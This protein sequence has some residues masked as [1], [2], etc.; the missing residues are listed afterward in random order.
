MGRD[1]VKEELL[2]CNDEFRR[3]Y[4]EHRQYDQ[5]LTHLRAKS[6]LSPDD[7]LEAKRIKIH[8]LQLKDRMEMIIRDHLS[9]A[10]V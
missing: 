5:K 2:A 6:A 7:E 9:S 8:K 10:T 4:Q 3:L 1:D